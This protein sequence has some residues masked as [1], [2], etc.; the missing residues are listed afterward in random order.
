MGQEEQ[1]REIM[2]IICSLLIMLIIDLKSVLA[3]GQKQ[4]Q[5]EKTK[6]AN[7]LEDKKKKNQPIS[8]QFE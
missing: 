8:K 7:A 2:F 1:K 4:S 3:G 5:C 6:G